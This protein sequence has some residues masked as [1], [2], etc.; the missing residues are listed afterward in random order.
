MHHGQ[1]MKATVETVT[2]LVC[3]CFP[4]K[5]QRST[6]IPPDPDNMHVQ[7]RFNRSKGHPTRVP[8]S[9]LLDASVIWSHET[10]IC[11][12]VV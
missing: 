4:S 10:N 8:A 2:I 5:H 7:S 3:L 11:G 1:N 12:G 6:C 9:T